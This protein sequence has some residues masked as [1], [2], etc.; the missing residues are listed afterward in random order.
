MM[1]I[2][3]DHLASRYHCLPS[4]AMSRATTFDLYVLD[5]ANRYEKRQRDI[6]EG[7]APETPKLTQDEMQAMVN[8]V[9]GQ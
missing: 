6:A 5:V 1:T 7:R 3:L 8:A 2:T 9:R 4:E